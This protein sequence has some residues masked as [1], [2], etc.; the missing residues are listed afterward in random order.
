MQ[1]VKDEMKSNAII[2]PYIP[3]FELCLRKSTHPAYQI[4][5]L[6]LFLSLISMAFAGNPKLGEWR[7]AEDSMEFTDDKQVHI[8]S[9]F[10]VYSLLAYHKVSPV[11][12]AVITIGIGTLKEVYDAYVPWE[13]YGIWGGDGFSKYDMVYNVMGTFIAYSVGKLLKDWNIKMNTGF[14]GHKGAYTAVSLHFHV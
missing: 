14:L 13:I 12:S 1:T 2:M 7:L 11:K 5:K 9:S 6:F 3:T 4:L 10:S 8:L